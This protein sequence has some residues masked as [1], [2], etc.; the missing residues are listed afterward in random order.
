MVDGNLDNPLDENQRRAP[1]GP[2][3]A[4][5]VTAA[6]V[7]LAAGGAGVA[8]ATSG[9]IGNGGPVETGFVVSTAETAPGTTDDGAAGSGGSSDGRDRECE[10]GRS[11]GQGSTPSEEPSAPSQEPSSPAAPST[12]QGAPSDAQEQ[13]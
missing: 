12:P 11:G 9:G 7:I 2:R 8:Y 6:T 10:K 1:R 4:L 5:L 13:L 3:R